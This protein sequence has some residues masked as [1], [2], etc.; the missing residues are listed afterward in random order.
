M[1][2]VLQVALLVEVTVAVELMINIKNDKNPEI[3]REIFSAQ[4]IKIK[5]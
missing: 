3:F 5:H 2:V 1:A 4:N